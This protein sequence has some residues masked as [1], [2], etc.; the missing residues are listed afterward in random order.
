MM[1]KPT[2][3]K[4]LTKETI[5]KKVGIIAL[6]LLLVGTILGPTETINAAGNLTVYDNPD[7]NFT[8]V[9]DW[10]YAN[11]GLTYDAFW[12]ADNMYAPADG[13]KVQFNF[14]GTTLQIY[15]QPYSYYRSERIQVTIDGE[16]VGEY[17]QFGTPRQSQMLYQI[18]GLT[19]REHSVE[20]HSIDPVADRDFVFDYIIIDGELLPYQ[21]IEERTEM[22]NDTV[23][24]TGVNEISYSNGWSYHGAQSG[25]YQSDETYTNSPGSYFQVKFSGEQIKWYGAQ[26]NTHGRVAIYIDEKYVTEVDTY[27]P[28]RSDQVLLYES[29][30]LAQGE[31]TLTVIVLPFK[32]PNSADR[33][34]TLDKLE[35]VGNYYQ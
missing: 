12:N 6:L 8:Y 14:T 19:D 34:I 22:I 23:S 16:V 31:H 30:I 1:K 28:I 18:G 35:V 11:T 17:H 32:S 2:I 3:N 10:I 26:N 25:A 21:P 5:M 15:S 9:G 33:Y 20:L 13:S 27:Q 29:A 4:T 24:G 7:S